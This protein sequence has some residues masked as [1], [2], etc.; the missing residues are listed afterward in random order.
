MALHDHLRSQHT[1][2][3]VHEAARLVTGTPDLDLMF[4]RPLG[5]NHLAADRGRRFLTAAIPGAM[6]PIHIVEPGYTRDESEVLF[7]VPAH[8]FAEQLLPAVAV[9][10]QCRISVAFLESYN[11]GVRLL[12]AVVYAGRGCIEEALRTRV[13][14]CDQH[15]GVGQ[16]AEHAEGFVVLDET[17]PAHISRE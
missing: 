9:L 3:D 4:T 11:I 5:L 12:L 10:R 1:I 15:V 6:R 16:H 13:F 17:H 7:E 8:A 14:G 2:I